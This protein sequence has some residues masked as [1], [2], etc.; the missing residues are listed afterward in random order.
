MRKLLPIAVALLLFLLPIGGYGQ[1]PSYGNYGGGIALPHEPVGGVASEETLAFLYDLTT[2]ASPPSNMSRIYVSSQPGGDLPMGVDTAA[3][4]AEAPIRTLDRVDEILTARGCNVEIILDS[5]DLWTGATDFGSGLV[6]TAG[7]GGQI[8]SCPDPDGVDVYIHSSDPNIRATIDCTG[9]TP[10][11]GVFAFSSALVSPG[12]IVIEGV[13]VQHCSTDVFDASAFTQ[14]LVVNSGTWMTGGS[15]NDFTTHDDSTMVGIN[16]YAHH[17]YSGGAS[18]PMV[19]PVSTSEMVIISNKKFTM[20]DLLQ[21]SGANPSVVGMG[22]GP[23]GG[24]VVVGLDM[25]QD[26]AFNGLGHALFM[27]PVAG[28]AS[29]VV[30]ARLLMN[31]FDNCIEFNGAGNNDSTLN[32]FQST[33]ANSI[34]GI[35]DDLTHA[36]A[37]GTLVAQCVVF[38]ELS[39]EVVDNANP[40]IRMNVNISDSIYDSDDIA[41]SFIVDGDVN[42]TLALARADLDAGNCA[43]ADGNWVNLFEDAVSLAVESMAIGNDGVVWDADDDNVVDANYIPQEG[44]HPDQECWGTCDETLEIALPDSL[45]LPDWVTGAVFS[46]I[47]IGGT[48]QNIGAR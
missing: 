30:G 34:D 4:T 33:C 2:I 22:P 44:C 25:E 47:Y 45:V 10:G 42:A 32:L 3:G 41:N 1:V 21:D 31:G 13:H 11:T 40:C 29:N 36:D 37:S 39:G 24:V 18:G 12:W 8:G 46:S 20:V 38:E 6:L 48:D 9:G 35:V 26:G 16:V 7:G 23:D 14:M 28:T 27:G 43:V 5:Y 15:N 17:D 19:G